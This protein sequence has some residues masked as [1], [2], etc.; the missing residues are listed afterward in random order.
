M[1]DRVSKKEK[2][3]LSEKEEGNRTQPCGSLHFQRQ[4]DDSHG[5][6]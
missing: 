4:W 1:A 6:L 3:E 2:E 5:R